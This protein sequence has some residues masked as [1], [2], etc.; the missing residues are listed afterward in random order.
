MNTPS[1][2]DRSKVPQE[3]I[4]AYMA[5]M[6]QK[7]NAGETPYPKYSG[8]IT[9]DYIDSLLLEMRHLDAV[10][11]DTSFTLFGRNFASPIMTAALSHLG[12]IR[13]TAAEEFARGAAMANAV[14]WTG[15]GS[16]EELETLTATGAA[17][18]KIIKPYRDNGL[19]LE[20]LDHARNCGVLAVGMDVDHAFNRHGDLDSFDGLEFGPK[21]A[22]ELEE[23]VRA[24]QLPFV[25][26]GVLSVTDALKC[27][28]AGVAGIV[29]SHHNG[30]MDYA[31]PPMMVLPE[32]REAVGPEMKIFVDCSL[33]TGMDAFKAIALGADACSYGRHLQKA[34]V[35]GGAEGVAFEIDQLTRQLVHTMEMT[36]CP[37]LK[38]I[39]STLIHKRCF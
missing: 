17:V 18:V 19:I 12:N 15:M 36:A 14:L 31:V 13:P 10:I 30:R 7:E 33:E 29:L 20:K 35:K 34:L 6:K 1:N 5:K 22:K 9:R 23:F 38:H 3:V 32:I 25:V 8:K 39:D 11:P 28:D 24:A 26:K 16:N 37:D 4:D 27:R 2:F 21:T